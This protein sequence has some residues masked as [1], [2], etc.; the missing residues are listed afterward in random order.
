MTRHQCPTPTYDSRQTGP[1]FHVTTRLGKRTLGFHHP[2]ADPFVRQVVH[3]AWW[4]RLKSLLRRDFT[5]E[6]VV[7]GDPQIIDDVLDLDANNLCS[8]G[9]ARRRDFHRQIHATLAQQPQPNPGIDPADDPVGTVRDLGDPAGFGDS[10][11]IGTLNRYFIKW[12]PTYDLDQTHPWVAINHEGGLQRMPNDLMVGRP[13]VP[14][15]ELGRRLGHP[16]DGAAVPQPR[17]ARATTPAVGPVSEAG[18]DD[19]EEQW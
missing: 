14:L 11:I 10:S 13:V 3:I 15:A 7:S 16:V 12:A 2:I 6:V 19:A 5:V 4:D 18:S 8:S 9:S 1:R 17:A